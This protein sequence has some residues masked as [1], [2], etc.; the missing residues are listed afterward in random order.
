MIRQNNG[1]E[2]SFQ[3]KKRKKDGKEL[4]LKITGNLNHLQKYSICNNNP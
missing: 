4:L 2:K 1:I 3:E